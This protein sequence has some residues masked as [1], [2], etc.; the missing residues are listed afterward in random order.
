MWREDGMR[1]WSRGFAALAM[2]MSL[3][4]LVAFGG[5]A[6]AG[7]ADAN[8]SYV[9]IL[10]SGNEVPPNA[11]GSQG[12]AWFHINGD[13]QSMDYSVYFWN[14]TNPQMGHIHLG[15][16]GVNGPVVVP[17]FNS[18]SITGN[19]SGMIASGTVT[20]SSLVGPLQGKSID[21][22]FSAMK[23]GGAYVNFHTIK[24]PAGETRGPVV[25]DEIAR[26]GAG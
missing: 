4:G 21:D 19:Y 16:P 15:G 23:S 5:V 18:T 11:E 26:L 13:G 12:I 22:L 7:T 8:H 2:L 14:I 20:A 25:S 24:L 6:S 1:A 3:V 10:Q 9:A 17:L